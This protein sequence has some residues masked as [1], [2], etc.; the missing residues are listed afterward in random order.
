MCTHNK[1]ITIPLN[2]IVPYELL[3]GVGILEGSFNRKMSL[4]V[5]ERE[6]ANLFVM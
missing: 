2:A 1:T 3:H 6:H 4:A 5:I